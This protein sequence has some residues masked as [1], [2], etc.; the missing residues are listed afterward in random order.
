[1]ATGD[2]YR[3]AIQSNFTGVDQIVNVF[4][5]RQTADGGAEPNKALACILAWGV[6]AEASYL[7]LLSARITLELFQAKGVDG[8]TEE[9]ELGVTLNGTGGS[10]DIV[11][12]TS[13]PIISW[14]TGQAGRRK[15]GRSYLPPAE[16]ANQDAGNLTSG[17]I[18]EL[19]AFAA[20]AL[21]VDTGEGD[22]FELVIFSPE[23]LTASPPRSGTIITPVTAAIVRSNMGTQRRRRQGV[24]S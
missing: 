18:T 16:E 7:D 21:L 14:R 22:E 6:T 10:G 2:T 24:G 8:S 23:N 5:Y 20:A 19:E 11:P 4:H 13:S 3:L 17:A 15:R 9:A 1:M 12:L